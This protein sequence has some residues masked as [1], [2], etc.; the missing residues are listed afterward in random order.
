MT[1]EDDKHAIALEDEAEYKRLVKC[2]LIF[3]APLDGSSIM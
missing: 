2:W 3:I 1:G